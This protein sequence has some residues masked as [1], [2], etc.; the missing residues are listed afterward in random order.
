[1]RPTLPRFRQRSTCLRRDPLTSSS[2]TSA[3]PRSGRRSGSGPGP[4]ARRR[5]APR[6]LSQHRFN[7][8]DFDAFLGSLEF[9]AGNTVGR[10]WRREERDQASIIVL[11]RTALFG[12]ANSPRAEPGEGHIICMTVGEAERIGIRAAASPAPGQDIVPDPIPAKVHVAMRTVAAHELA[13][14]YTIEDEYGGL[15]QATIA[16]EGRAAQS[17]NAQSRDELLSGRTFLEPAQVALA[18]SGARGPAD[19]AAGAR[20]PRTPPVLR[21]W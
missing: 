11:C 17:A 14:S 12:G 13:H 4:S 15:G 8:D 21:T 7:E 18:A 6:L 3:T 1:M 2:S 5:C 9:P 10:R 20:R 19:L 16:D